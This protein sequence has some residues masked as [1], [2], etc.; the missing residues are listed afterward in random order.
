MQ[1]THTTA[2]TGTA[3]VSRGNYLFPINPKYPQ[4]AD[5]LWHEYLIAWIN[6]KGRECSASYTDES[7]TLAKLHAL[8]KLGVKI[9][10]TETRFFAGFVSL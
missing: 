2:E 6:S 10:K 1:N 8:R 4:T 3:Q 5:N 7:K 9:T